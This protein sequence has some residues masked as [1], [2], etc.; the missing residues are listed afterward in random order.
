[1]FRT[2]PWIKTPVAEVHR[3]ERADAVSAWEPTWPSRAVSV[4]FMPTQ[5][6]RPRKMAGVSEPKL[7][8]M[9]A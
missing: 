2:R 7:R 3:S 6:T 4:T 5:P 8:R 1:M 9:L